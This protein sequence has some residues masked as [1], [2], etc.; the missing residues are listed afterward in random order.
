MKN[1]QRMRGGI[2]SIQKDM[3]VE[4]PAGKRPVDSSGSPIG[5][6]R[7]DPSRSYVGI[8]ALLQRY[9]NDS[10][11]EAWEEIKSRINYTCE[12]I[13]SALE[14]LEK[15]TNFSREVK[16]RISL[17]QK[18][19]FKPNLVNPFNIDPQ[20]HGPD[21]G[22]T[23]CT[24]WPFLAALM[25]WFHDRL[26]I[27][28]YQM[29]LGEAATC[30][31]AAAALF[32]RINPQNLR[33]TPEM[34]MEGRMGSFYG[35]WGFY[36]V[37]QYLKE[38]LPIHADDD[39][40]NGYEDSLSGVYQPPGLAGHK[41]MVY[42]L[43]RIFDDPGK[44]R[45]VPVPYG[46]N[47]RSIML[48]KAVVGGNPDDPDDLKLYPGSILVNVPK[49]KVHAIALFTNVI[50]NLGIG[51]Y[52]MQSCR[53]GQ[54]QWD[55]SGPHDS[56]PGMKSLIP[57]ETW[58]GEADPQT[59]FPARNPDGHFILKKTGGLAATM[60]DIIQAVRHQ[61]I[62]MI[63]VVDAI[64]AI[65]LDHQGMLFGLKEPEGLIFT[66]LDPVATD[67][68]CARYMFSNVSLQEALAAGLEDGCGGK[69]PQRVP[70]PYLKDNQILTRLDYDC[71]LGR[72]HCLKEAQKRGLGQ[73]C[74]YVNGKD[75]RTNEALISIEGH[76]GR[77]R[78]NVF[79]ELTTDHLY[80]DIFK[81]PWDLQK[82]FL[83]Y[84]GAI[85]TLAGTTKK[86]NFLHAFDE[87]QNGI[88][89]YEEFGKKWVWGFQLNLGGH[90]VCQIGKEE[91]GHLRGMFASRA[92]S[93]KCAASNWNLSGHD[94]LEEYLYGGVAGTAYYMSQMQVEMPDFFAPGLSW[95]KGKWPSY[96]TAWFAYLGLTFYGD[97]FP[98]GIKYP[99][100]YAAA[101]HY[102]DLTQN[103][104]RYTGADPRHPDP[105]GIKTYLSEVSAN[106]ERRLDFTFYVPTGFDLIAGHS[107]SNVEVAA[108]PQKVLTASFHQGGEV[109]CG[110]V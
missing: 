100:L 19:L 61:G 40:F 99:S 74:Y 21:I 104:G 89:M 86:K 1:R 18:L 9:I 36:F 78:D 108:D 60:I 92:T 53:K 59:G 67:L 103:S 29:A 84:L 30:I 28:Y 33:A 107:I 95:G 32:T 20:S 68:L 58:V 34:V 24:E 45:E 62:Y 80:Y 55:Y 76:L 94:I 106:K 91:L 66:G 96:Q 14:A 56:I 15:E 16:S 37:R 77:I 35:G 52:P 27:R 72:D 57:H 48:H 8:G 85:D 105:D 31:P 51:L 98:Y 26:D 43:N 17:G 101:F 7:L 23:A 70:V 3:V 4:T 69:F 11:V 90:Y 65:N 110:N 87:D 88:V 25:R 82:T 71:P 49:L 47:F 42:D 73:L 109:W 102:A 46:I 79:S 10:N 64:E 6:V 5:V 22:S 12:S 41:L 75:V 83:E 54:C 93:L 97:Q 2:M 39:P 38:M 44:G 81:F 13:D 50:K 63:N